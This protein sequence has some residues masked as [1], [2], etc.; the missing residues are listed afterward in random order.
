MIGDMY[1]LTRAML[2]NPVG[3]IGYVFNEYSDFDDPKGRGIQII[4]SN[5][6]YDGFSV[7]EQ[8]LFLQLVGFSG[9]VSGYEF[10]NVMWVMRDFRDGYWKF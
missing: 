3:A 4:F 9:R 1:K 7:I 6:N 10:H 8:T 2:G 5:G